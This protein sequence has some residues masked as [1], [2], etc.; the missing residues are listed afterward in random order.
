M[1]YATRGSTLPVY[2]LLIASVFAICIISLPGCSGCWRSAENK[3][4]KDKEDED[5]KKKEK[6]KPNFELARPRVLPR[7]EQSLQNFVKPRHWLTVSQMLRANNFDFTG[8]ILT[9]VTNE[10]GTPLD[11]DRVPF[12]L[13]AARP[14]ALAK[15]QPKRLEMI[16]YIPPRPTGSE[17]RPWLWRRLQSKGGG[18]EIPTP[19]D[20]EPTTELKPWQYYFVVLARSPDA[21]SNL[22][23]MHAVRPLWEGLDQSGRD[24]FYHVLLP[25]TDA[26]LPLPSN[27]ITWTSIANVLWDDVD[28]NILTADQQQA[29]LDWL[30]WGGQLIISGPNSLDALKSSFLSD[31]LPAQAGK[32]VDLEQPAF[33]ELNGTYW[34]VREKGRDIV[35]KINVLSAKPVAGIE[36]KLEKQAMLMPHTGGL[37]AERRV[38]RGRIVVTAFPLTHRQLHGWQGYDMFFNACL[39]RHP[40]REYSIDAEMH[41]GRIHW[42]EHKGLRTDSRLVSG[43]RIY[44]RDAGYSHGQLPLAAAVSTA[45]QPA[46]ST[47][48]QPDGGNAELGSGVN[49]GTV[50][51]EAAPWGAD[52][53]DPEFHS[54]PDGGVGSWTDFSAT[55]N[56]SRQALKDAAGIVIPE[57]RFVFQVLAVYLVVLVPVNW[58]LFRFI[59]RVEW[60]WFAA[61]VIAVLCGVAVVRLAQLDIGFARS[62]TEVAILEVHRDYDRAHLTRYTAL[63]SSLSSEYEIVFDD[64]S[65]LVQPFALDEN[66]QL[67]A[68]QLRTT[69]RFDYGKEQALRGFR[70]ASNS[71]SMLHS[72]QMYD[73]GGQLQLD[74]SDDIWRLANQTDVNVLDV[75]VAHRVDAQTVRVAWV[76]QLDSGASTPLDFRDSERRRSLET[77]DDPLAGKLSLQRLMELVE[78]ADVLRPGDVRMVGWTPERLPGVTIR[79]A[80]SQAMS[81][82]LVLAHLRFGAWPAPRPDK[83]TFQDVADAR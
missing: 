4:N 31:H 61:P 37:V 81:R 65:A 26:Q 35:R 70:V 53:V 75:G 78:N 13:T 3:E 50:T 74:D 22:K 48:V 58:C 9:A 80:A 8:E 44:T 68:G 69:V 25:R 72:E 27:P 55:A 24:V 39:L 76:G 11:L 29:L 34:T 23:S 82:T 49:D 47:A 36:L 19:N 43:L 10:T 18:R 79:P 28:P 54:N 38:G 1:P 14:A 62:R 56:L 52:D 46:V 15:G 41:E 57:A 30:H 67:L 63:Y 21:Y 7:D 2:T 33:A 83:N 77:T 59:G 71:T 42:S 5:K 16:Y 60:A 40:P 17:A 32:S 45:V 20:T 51:G 6:P 12:R 66:F 64:D 73:M